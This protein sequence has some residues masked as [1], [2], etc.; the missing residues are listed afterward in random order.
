[1]AIE[2]ADPKG[3]KPSK[4]E[5]VAT[6]DNITPK[7]EVKGRAVAKTA[8]STPNETE[9]IQAVTFR[10]LYR[11]PMYMI[12]ESR[13]IKFAGGLYTTKDPEE[14]AFFRNHRQI[15]TSMWE[16]EY[17]K[18]VLEKKKEDKQWIRLVNEDDEK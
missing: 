3:K 14:I 12:T 9:E 2:S 1:M 8:A 7:E 11:A 4:P 16:G 5:E 6:E 13:Y 10:S 15:G 17:P 18:W